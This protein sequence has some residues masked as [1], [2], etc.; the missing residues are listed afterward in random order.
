MDGLA[1]VVRELTHSMG[2][3][4]NI[5]KKGNDSLQPDFTVPALKNS[6]KGSKAVIFQFPDHCDIDVGDVVVQVGARDR[7][8]VTETEDVVIQNRFSHLEVYVDKEGA[9][10]KAPIVT[11][12]VYNLHGPNSRI[13]HSSIDNSTNISG[14]SN[15]DLIRLV[16]DL[17]ETIA[18]LKLDESIQ[19]EAMQ[20]VE[21]IQ[22]QSITGKPSK[23]I[24]SSLVSGL[25]NLLPHAANI[26]TIGS[27]IL[28]H[29]PK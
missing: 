2:S 29:L 7:W 5:F 1:D 24:L 19:T 12:V 16:S 3:N 25:M 10:Q 27:A 22:S 23:T 9:R 13:S 4:V 20:I 21:I 28:D 11:N 26:A 17:R 18:G 8:V 6:K 15:S 14:A